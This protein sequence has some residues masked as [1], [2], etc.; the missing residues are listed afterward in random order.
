M[1]VDPGV[2][3]SAL[4]A[5]AATC[6]DNFVEETTKKLSLQFSASGTSIQ[7]VRSIV[8]AAC[9]KWALAL[10]LQPQPEPKP[11]RAQRAPKYKFQDFG[12]ELRKGSWYCVPCAMPLPDSAQ[13]TYGVEVH[14][15]SDGHDHAVEKLRHRY[16]LAGG[17][18]SRVQSRAGAKRLREAEEDKWR[19]DCEQ[20]GQQAAK[21][22]KTVTEEEKKA[23]ADANNADKQRRL[24]NLRT[25]P[26]LPRDV[27]FQLGPLQLPIDV[28]SAAERHK[29]LNTSFLKCILTAN[30]PM[31][32]ADSMHECLTC[33]TCSSMFFLVFSATPFFIV[34]SY[35]Q[36][37]TVDCSD[38]SRFSQ[39]L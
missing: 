34:F 23:Q 30:V 22:R 10:T 39:V 4:Q 24:T 5:A 37:Q 29:Q 32:M 12:M 26:C 16:C 11:E 15:V 19:K 3:W 13:K 9:R 14:V 35:P 25:L 8:E 28:V 38:F 6:M 21:K 36:M 1:L 33:S 20:S 27:T 18:E 7:R 2:D 31:R 17:Y